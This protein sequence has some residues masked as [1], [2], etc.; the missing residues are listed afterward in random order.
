MA[1]RTDYLPVETSGRLVGDFRA[2]VGSGLEVGPM[3]IRRDK[4][5]RG[6]KNFRL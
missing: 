1:L 5:I 6:L 2:R 3:K 4:V